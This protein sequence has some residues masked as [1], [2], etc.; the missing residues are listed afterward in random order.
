M[1]I[2][3]YKIKIEKEI[4]DKRIIIHPKSS[5]GKVNYISFK[6]DGWKFHEEIDIKSALNSWVTQIESSIPKIT[7]K[8]IV[9]LFKIFVGDLYTFELAE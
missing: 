9:C 3:G 8:D 5:D 1:K 4:Q 2:F 6:G 7:A